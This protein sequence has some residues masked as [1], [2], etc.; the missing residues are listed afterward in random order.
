MKEL[1]KALTGVDNG[2]ASKNKARAK[3][4]EMPPIDKINYSAVYAKIDKDI[5]R[6]APMSKKTPIR[7]CP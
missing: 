2:G 4:K 5:I 7:T 6:G 3:A 1:M